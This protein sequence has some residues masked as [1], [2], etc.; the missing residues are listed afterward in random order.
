MSPSGTVTTTTP[1]YSWSASQGAQNYEL[2]VQNT[3][4]VAVDMTIPA[5]QANC[6]LG[7]GTWSF[8]PPLALRDHTMYNW[9]VKASNQNGASA[10]SAPMA[11]TVDTGTT[12]PGG[13]PA[14]TTMTAPASTVGTTT[15]TYSWNAVPEATS[16][17]LIVQ[18]TQGV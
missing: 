15:P 6:D 7:T 8:T 16:Y 9:F 4:G 11:I 5:A 3:Q 13:P 18:N 2:L 10:W 1:T 17:E 12:T 14:A